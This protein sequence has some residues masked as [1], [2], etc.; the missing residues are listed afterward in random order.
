MGAL[1][2]RLREFAS[3]YANWDGLRT[4]CLTFDADFA[5][6]YMVE[7]VLSILDEHDAAATVFATHACGPLVGAAA[8]GRLEIGTHPNLAA[9]STHDGDLVGVVAELR[10]AYPEAVGNRF[11]VLAHSYR[12]LVTLSRAGFR[13]D[14]S[15]LRFNCSHVLPA[16]HPDLSMVLL[17]YTWEDGIA[18]NAGLQLGLDAVELESPGLKIVNFHPVNV[19][20]NGPDSGPRLELMRQVGRI[21]DCPRETAERLRSPAAAGAE[22]TLR[23]LLELA[24]SREIRLAR[25]RDIAAAF[26]DAHA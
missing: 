22:R 18:E 21:S 26:A 16:W 5:P 6:D 17:T 10:R 2:E 7:H 23:D 12:D 25:L 20:L 13:Y 3:D 15:T 19:F 9:G 24:A 8:A 14:I 11:H 1:P 4:L